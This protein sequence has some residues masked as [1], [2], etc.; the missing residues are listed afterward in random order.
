MAETGITLQVLPLDL[1]E[2]GSGSFQW[3]RFYRDLVQTPAAGSDAASLEESMREITIRRKDDLLRVIRKKDHQK[4]SSGKLKFDFGQG[5][6]YQK[7]F[8]YSH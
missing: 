7:F 5:E 2:G 6:G 8:K 4:R 3:S 1:G